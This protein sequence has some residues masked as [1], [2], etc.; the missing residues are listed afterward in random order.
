[1]DPFT[2]EQQAA[3]RAVIDAEVARA[4]ASQRDA[5]AEQLRQLRADLEAP[6]GISAWLRGAARSWTMWSGALLVVLPELM[7]AAA[8]L[9]TETMGPE[10]WRRVVQVIGIVV[11]ILRIRTTQSLPEKGAPT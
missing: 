7:D 2:P 11:V 6:S 4:V 8:P 10:A 1:M 5:F 9:V 3:I